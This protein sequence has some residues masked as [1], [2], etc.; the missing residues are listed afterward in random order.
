[1]L[2]TGKLL[3]AAVCGLQSQKQWVSISI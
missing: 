2:I 1:M 3:P